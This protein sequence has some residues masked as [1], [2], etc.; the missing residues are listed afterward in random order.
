MV[1]RSDGHNPPLSKVSK[2]TTGDGTQVVVHGQ[3]KLTKSLSCKAGKARQ[4][5]F[6][7]RSCADALIP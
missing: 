7:Y 4:Q 2:R 1:Y 6:R 3:A 5:L